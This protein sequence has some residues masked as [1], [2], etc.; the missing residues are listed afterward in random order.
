MNGNLLVAVVP[1]Q[2]QTGS[3]EC[4]VKAIAN[5]YHAMCGDDLATVTFSEELDMRKHLSLCFEKNRFSRFPL[6]LCVPVQ[7]RSVHYINI[8][9]S[10]K[11]KRPNSY[12]NMIGCDG[13]N[14]WY[15]LNCARVDDVPDG[16]WY[17]AEC[18]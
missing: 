1:V 8:E 5:A 18:S 7:E 11:C 14:K 13:C 4:G 9:V 16:D 12:Q 3:T 17:C 6:S 2:Q 15:H 10:C